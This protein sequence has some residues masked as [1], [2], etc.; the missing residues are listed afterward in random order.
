M[1]DACCCWVATAGVMLLFSGC[2][3]FGNAQPYTLV[4]GAVNVTELLYADVT[5]DGVDDL[6]ASDLRLEGSPPRAVRVQVS[7]SLVR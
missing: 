6:L 5:G 4:E 1:L 3:I 2:I 7:R